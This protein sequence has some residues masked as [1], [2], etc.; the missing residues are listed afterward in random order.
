MFFAFL[1]PMCCACFPPPPAPLLHSYILGILARA[2]NT[3]CA[4]FSG[5]FRARVAKRFNRVLS[6]LFSLTLRS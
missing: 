2:A 5:Q 4:F 3:D 6:L 1:A